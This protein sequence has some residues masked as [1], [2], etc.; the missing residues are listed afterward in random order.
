MLDTLPRLTPAVTLETDRLILRPWHA[1]DNAPFAAMNA[2]PQV[3]EF[4]PSVCTRAQSDAIVDRLQQHNNT[5]GWSFWAT[6]LR[7]SGEFIGFIGLQVPRP[8]VPVY[9]CVEVGWRLARAHWGQ[10]Y[11]TEGARAS[12]TFGFKEL[13]L[14]NIV[15]FVAEENHRSRAVMHRLGMTD[16]HQPFIHP[17]VTPEARHKMHCLYKISAEEWLV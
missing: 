4:F 10:G 16:Q 1:L 13:N 7:A 11:A 17:L 2:D 6:E 8:E 5:W 12:L 3:M 9:P 14:P 15:A